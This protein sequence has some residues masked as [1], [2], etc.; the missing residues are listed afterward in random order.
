ME[1][2]CGDIK[3]RV[4]QECM[5]VNLKEM[6]MFCKKVFGEYTKEK[7]QNCCSHEKRLQKEYWQ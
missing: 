7:W 3:N 4:A 6:Q 1:L 2:V 5:S